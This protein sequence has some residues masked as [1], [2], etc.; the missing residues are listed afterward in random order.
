MS[1]FTNNNETA[2]IERM[3]ENQAKLIAPNEFIKWYLTVNPSKYKHIK[4]ADYNRFECVATVT[5]CYLKSRGQIE[6][7]G[8][9]FGSKIIFSEQLWYVCQTKI[10]NSVELDL[11]PA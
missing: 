11:T 5:R 3:S 1:S 10:A 6:P 2:E 7:V 9:R 4:F 8:Y